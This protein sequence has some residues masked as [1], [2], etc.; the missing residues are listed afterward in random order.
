MAIAS[1]KREQA[2]HAARVDRGYPWLIAMASSK[3]SLQT[4]SP[5]A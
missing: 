4:R 2:L 1:L 5:F 3:G